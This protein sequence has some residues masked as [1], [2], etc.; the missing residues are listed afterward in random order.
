MKK[1]NLN[2]QNIKILKLG[3]KKENININLGEMKLK[4]L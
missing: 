1:N 3:E 4:Y 2:Q